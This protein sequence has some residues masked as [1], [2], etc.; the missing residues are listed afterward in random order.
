MGVEREVRVAF[1]GQD[2]EVDGVAEDYVAYSPVAERLDVMDDAIHTPP[3]QLGDDISGAAPNG[4]GVGVVAVLPSKRAAWT[5]HGEL[6]L[7]LVEYYPGTVV[8]DIGIKPAGEHRGH[9]D[10]GKAKQVSGIGFPGFGL[11][12]QLTQAVL[13]FQ[14]VAIEVRG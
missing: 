4:V 10:I 6:A 9:A 14:V 1:E 12:Q 3:V 5:R 2:G 13:I 7:Y 8:L 11:S